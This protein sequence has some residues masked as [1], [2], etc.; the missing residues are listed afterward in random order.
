MEWYKP[1]L[2]K[3]Q[4]WKTARFIYS[5]KKIVMLKKKNNNNNDNSNCYTLID[6]LGVVLSD[7]FSMIL[8]Y[9]SNIKITLKYNNT[10]FVFIESKRMKQKKLLLANMGMKSMIQNGRIRYNRWLLQL[11]DLS[12]WPSPGKVR[13]IVDC[14]S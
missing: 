9:I 2:L 6:V 13:Y 4:H 12:Y 8:F 1:N 3:S 14:G 10:T 5:S 7:I 11:L